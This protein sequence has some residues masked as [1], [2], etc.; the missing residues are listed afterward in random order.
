M[1]NKI[2]KKTI[3]TIILAFGVAVTL[4][5]A[6]TPQL[7]TSNRQVR[8]VVDRIRNRTVTLQREIDRVRNYDA[9]TN[10][11]ERLSN[12]LTEFVSSLNELR[13][14]TYT[15]SRSPNEVNDILGSANR[16]NRI[17]SRNNTNA[18]IS[19]QWAA[20]RS[21]V[22]ILAGYYGVSGNWNEPFPGNGSGY[23]NSGLTGTYRLNTS[24]SDDVGDVLDR[25]M[26]SY[27]NDQRGNMRRNLERRLASPEMIVIEKNGRT[28]TLASGNQAQVT[29]EA[30]G[31]VRTETNQR[32]RTITTRATSSAN[33]LTI[34]YS[35]DRIND[36]NVNFA[37]DRTG[38][39]RVT[40]RI[41]LENRNETVSISSVYDR[42]STVADFSS[43]GSPNYGGN[44]GGS[45]T[46][47][48]N[49]FYVPNNTRLTA[50]LNGE[51]NTKTSKVGDRFTMDVTSPNQYRDAVIEGHLSETNSSGRVSGR[52][53]LTL[54]F[55]TITINGNR[56]TFAGLIES[57]T[58]S[59]GD[60][61]TVDNEGM[62]RDNSQTKKTV[63]RAGIGAVL[64]AVIGAIAGGGSGAAI[65]A[66]VGAGAGAG[67]VLIAGRDNLELGSGSTFMITATS[68]ANT[69]NRN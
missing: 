2:L 67:T 36:F 9:N 44:N 18:R 26:N 69:V 46:G 30:D 53:N 29:F 12:R 22:N 31:V 24:Q 32:G 35:G 62:I 50:T 13:S 10:A 47:N 6:Q 54:S 37:V 21:D 28:I 16:I 8:S 42:L 39:L 41:Y 48:I 33:N 5:S 61:V 1:K 19:S 56:Y 64:G 52:A 60:S 17:F 51:I 59:N 45:G 49:G 11:E 68:P 57:V 43:I 3:I 38:V 40:R 55:D 66:G 27:G 4:V 23:P 25:S 7:Q 34:D 63:T 20:I 15:N 14:A 58:S 65:G